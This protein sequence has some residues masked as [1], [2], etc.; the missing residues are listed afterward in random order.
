MACGRAVA[1]SNSTA[2]PEVADAAAVLFDP[3]SIEEMA[4]AIRDVLLDPELRGRLKRLG[5]QRA[6][7]FTWERAA[8]RT[9]DVYYDVVGLSRPAE[10]SP[11]RMAAG[12]V[13]P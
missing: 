10:V 5:V 13:T 7:M 6:A 12:R 11:R 8:R 1:C 3:T 2:M 4:R 9:L